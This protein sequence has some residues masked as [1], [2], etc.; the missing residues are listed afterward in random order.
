MN[1]VHEHDVVAEIER[2]VRRELGRDIVLAAHHG[3]QSDLALD[4]LVL[5]T[6]AVELEDRY[7]VR[8]REEDT[9]TTHTV[10]DLA[11]LVV[12]RSKEQR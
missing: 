10:G 6:L 1:E 2:V 5:M 7:R 3:L 4:S 9:D 8:L 11:Q 12:R